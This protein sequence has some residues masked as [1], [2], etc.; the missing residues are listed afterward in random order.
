L[1]PF[2]FLLLMLPAGRLHAQPAGRLFILAEGNG[3][4]PGEVGLVRY[5]QL[6]YQKLFELEAYGNDLYVDTADA[7]TTWL[8]AVGGIPFGQA[9]PGSVYI[10]NLRTGSMVDTLKDVGARQ[11]AFWG[12][13]L[14]VA[15]YGSSRLAVFDRAN[16]HQL[17]WAL[18]ADKLGPEAE[19]VFVLGN[20][21]YVSLPGS[22]GDKDSVA[23]VDLLAQDTL[24]TL[25]VPHNPQNFA[26]LANG[27][28]W[29]QSLNYAGEG[30]IVTHIDTLSKTPVQIDTTK[31]SSYGGFAPDGNR[32]LF[33]GEQN[34]KS[35]YLLG[36]T[37]ASEQVDTL[38]RPSG[39]PPQLASQNV[40]GFAPYYPPAAAPPQA[41]AG[42]IL[43][44]TNFSGADT[45]FTLGS[46]PTP[47]LVAAPTGVRRMQFVAD[48]P[49]GVTSR[50]RASHS[51]ASPF[52][53][54]PN[55][56]TGSL[57]IWLPQGTAVQVHSLQGQLL[58]R[59][60][61]PVLDLAALPAGSYLLQAAGYQPARLLKQ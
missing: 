44:S 8:Y 18:G 7:D 9:T 29:L 24:K 3:S 21:A 48:A 17:V 11:L 36:Y 15:G 12:Q 26:L 13:Y 32:L 46:A 61:A 51:Q 33:T 28:L 16:H 27:Q 57:R 23:V 60:T 53:F 54:G 47:G 20:Y 5:P 25:T 42:F 37:P 55:P 34:F 30:L 6:A 35:P 45:L 43:S 4:T 39:F 40:Y 49:P 10:Y 2:L 1:V 52:S 56:T 59:G 38:L 41:A 22:L 14:L 58:L 50:T 31:I 19:D